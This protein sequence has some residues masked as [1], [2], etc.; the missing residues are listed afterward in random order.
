[1]TLETLTLPNSIYFFGAL[2]SASNLM[3]FFSASEMALIA[4]DEKRPRA[5]TVMPFV[6]RYSRFVAIVID[7]FMISFIISATYDSVNSLVPPIFIYSRK[8]VS[9]PL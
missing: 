4:A 7:P 3:P 8:L 2:A 5:P 9:L 1:M 6:F